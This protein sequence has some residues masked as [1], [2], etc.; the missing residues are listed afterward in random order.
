M[1]AIAATDGDNTALSL[2]ESSWDVC[3]TWGRLHR[4]T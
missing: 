3:G 2:S 4:S 1:S